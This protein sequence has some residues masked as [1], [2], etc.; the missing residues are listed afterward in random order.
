MAN[1][2]SKRQRFWTLFQHLFEKPL[3]G[4]VHSQTLLRRVAGLHAWLCYPRPKDVRLQT[5]ELSGV[6]GHWCDRG[7]PIVA[8][9]HKKVVLWLHGGAFTVGGVGSHGAWAASLAAASGARAFLADYRLAPEHPFPAAPEDAEAA[10]RG[11]LAAGY[12][13]SSIAVA[14][15]SAGGALAFALLARLRAA[16]LP[17]PAAI[18]AVS[19]WFDLSLSGESVR[20]NLRSEAMVPESWLR[21][22]AQLYANG[23]QLDSPAL[24]PLFETWDRPTPPTMLLVGEGE[25]LRDDTERMA[26]KL[27]DTGGQVEVLRQAGAGHIWPVRMGLTPEADYANNRIAA[28]LRRAFWPETHFQL[29]LAEER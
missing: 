7:Q 21:R 13:P 22:T 1:G 16:G 5:G 11:L 4:A 28:F 3:I 2:I 12:E 27:A 25:L 23:Q 9:G 6:A 29:D 15:D 19:P 20:T 10:Y 24:S 17:D 8:T 26:I 18:V 14:G